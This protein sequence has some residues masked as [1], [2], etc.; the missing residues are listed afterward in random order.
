MNTAEMVLLADKNGKIYYIDTISGKIFYNK[1]DGFYSENL[2]KMW[3]I[4]FIS[5]F[6]HLDEWKLNIPKYTH[7]DLVKLIEHD[8][9][10]I[11]KNDLQ[12]DEEWG[13]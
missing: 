9:E 4:N 5:G 11:F 3:K 12:E 13:M 8:F 7:D 10:Y 2:E 6:I 1:N